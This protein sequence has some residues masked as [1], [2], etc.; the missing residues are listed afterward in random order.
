MISNFKPRETDAGRR[1][2]RRL[3]HVGD[4]LKFGAA[5]LIFDAPN[6]L[7]VDTGSMQGPMDG[8]RSGPGLDALARLAFNTRVTMFNDSPTVHHTNYSPAA[9]DDQ[10][11]ARS[12]RDRSRLSSENICVAS[13]RLAL[14]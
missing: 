9:R 6:D 1:F 14:Q 11:D 10:G 3:T 13:V 7:V 5:N 12:V 2:W 8:D 4:Q